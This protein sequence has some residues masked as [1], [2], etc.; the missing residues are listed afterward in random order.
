MLQGLVRKALKDCTTVGAFDMMEQQGLDGEP[1]ML[2]YAT[3]R[4][5]AEF[6]KRRLKGPVRCK[7]TER[8]KEFRQGIEQAKLTNKLEL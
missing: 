5:A 7:E 2:L 3:A 4:E 8:C 6:A 1:S